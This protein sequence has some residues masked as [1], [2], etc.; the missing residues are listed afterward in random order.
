MNGSD[1]SSLGI[2]TKIRQ[3]HNGCDRMVDRFPASYVIGAYRP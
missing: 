1:M 2:Y 3:G